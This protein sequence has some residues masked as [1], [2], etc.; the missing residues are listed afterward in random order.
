M[1]TATF[2]YTSGPDTVRPAHN[3]RA[4]LLADLL[5]KCTRSRQSDGEPVSLRSEFEDRSF[6]AL[7]LCSPSQSSLLLGSKFIASSTERWHSNPIPGE[8]GPFF[9]HQRA[10]TPS[11]RDNRIT[12]RSKKKKVR[13]RGQATKLAAGS[14]AHVS[15]STLIQ[16]ECSWATLSQKPIRRGSAH[17]PF[18]FGW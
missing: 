1:S 4:V 17:L 15:Q 14:R 3:R 12:G 8:R 18:W 5:R 6:L 13:E 2:V 9:H 16:K 7:P 11:S 10:H